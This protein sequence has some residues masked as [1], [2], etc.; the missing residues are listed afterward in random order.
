MAL[1]PE[2]MGG[3][4]IPQDIVTGSFNYTR[5]DDYL[6]NLIQEGGA[7]CPSITLALKNGKKFQSNDSLLKFLQ[8]LPYEAPEG[9]KIN[10]THLVF[11]L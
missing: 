8:L 11:Y 9:E 4:F 6:K 3:R 1:P 5:Q 2:A 10:S 7:C